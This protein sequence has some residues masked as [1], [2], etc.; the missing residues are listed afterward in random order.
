MFQKLTRLFNS[1][2]YN[3]LWTALSA[4]FFISDLRSVIYCGGV[5]NVILAAFWLVMVLYYGQNYYRLTRVYGR[6]L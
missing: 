1:L 4:G 2:W 3:L 6:Y 5:L